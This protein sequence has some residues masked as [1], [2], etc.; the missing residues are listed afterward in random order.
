MKLPPAGT[1]YS[2][3]DLESIIADINKVTAYYFK[4]TKH[5]DTFDVEDFAE[6]YDEIAAQMKESRQRHR[7]EHMAA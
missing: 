2:R 7:T 4:L 3:I 1:P 6:R 5:E